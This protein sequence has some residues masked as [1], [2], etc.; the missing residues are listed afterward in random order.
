[1]KGH[2]PEDFDVDYELVRFVRRARA[3]AMGQLSEIHPEL[4]Y[5]TFVLLLAIRDMN[6]GV[7]ASELAEEMQVHKSTVSR[8][9]GTMERL[10]LIER[11]TH[12]DDARARLLTVT[13]DTQARIDAFRVSSHAWLADRLADWTADERATFARLLARLNDAA[14][15]NPPQPVVTS[16]ASS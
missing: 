10:G 16:S 7:Q 9:V 11:V 5:N 3:Y 1:M 4:D 13:D 12:P 6:G 2:L 14:E 8:A 15:N